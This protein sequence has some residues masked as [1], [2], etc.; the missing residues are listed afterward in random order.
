MTTSDDIRERHTRADVW[1]D[2]LGVNEAQCWQCRVAWPCDTTR[3]LAEA[4]RWRTDAE[5][6]AAALGLVLHGLREV[7]WDEPP[8]R[9]LPHGLHVADIRQAR[10]ALAAHDALKEETP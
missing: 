6:L 1:R 10:T 7:V 3:A 2:R 4:D 8:D 5:R 9:W